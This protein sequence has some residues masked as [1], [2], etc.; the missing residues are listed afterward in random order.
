MARVER[1][2]GHDREMLM[3]IHEF[4]ASVEKTILAHLQET[5]FI[6][7]SGDKGENREDILR[8]FLKEHLPKRYG[9][10]KGEIITSTG[11]R[12]H[13]VDIIVYDALNCPLLYSGKTVVVPVEG[14]Y[15]IIEVKSR[16]SK[17]ELL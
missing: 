2:P 4:F 10:V 1:I 3:D 15:G 8:D 7:H 5:G 6:G 16:L 11:Q 9:V 14:V 12:S 13:A 17:A